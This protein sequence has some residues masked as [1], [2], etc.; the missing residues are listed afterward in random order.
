MQYELI[1]QRVVCKTARFSALNN[2]L[3]RLEYSA[4]GQFEDSP[5]VIALAQPQPV[6]FKAIEFTDEG[7]L[8]LH[9]DLLHIVYRVSN[10]PFNDDNLKIHGMDENVSLSWTPSTVDT[11]NLGGTFTSVDLI[12]RKFHPSGVHPASVFHSYP[13]TQEWLYTA[14]K[15]IHKSL[16]ERGETTGFENPPLWYLD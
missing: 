7:V 13:H 8:H 16:R 10:E 6:P 1:D 9:T 2:G 15:S 11:D 5:T 4:S 14:L 12:H 3:V